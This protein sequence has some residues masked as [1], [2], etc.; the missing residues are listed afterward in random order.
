MKEI[1]VLQ[2]YTY[3]GENQEIHYTTHELQ[4]R[5]ESWEDWKPVPIVYKE[6]D[7]PDEA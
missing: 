5:N 4:Y 3:E 7:K 6:E 2:K 1:R